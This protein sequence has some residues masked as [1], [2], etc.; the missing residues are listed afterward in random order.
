M[1]ITVDTSGTNIA[2]VQFSVSKEDFDKEYKRGLNQV[3]SQ[4]R[5][6]G[7]RPGKVPMPMIEKH[8]GAEVRDEVKQQFLSRAY[9]KAVEDN[10]LK[11]M[12][13]PRVQ[14]DDAKMEDGG[15]FSMA[16]EIS[17]RPQFPMPD[18][19]GMSIESELEPVLDQNVDEALEEFRRQ[20][21][22]TEATE[23]GIDEKGLVLCNVIFRTGETEAFHRDG[24]RLSPES[25][26]PGVDKE[27]YTAAMIGKKAGETVELDM[28][29]PDTLPDESL[30]GQ[31]GT[32][33]IEITQ[34]FRTVPPT[35]EELCELLQLETTDE[36]RVKVRESLEE[37]AREREN[38]RVETVLLDRLIEAVEIELPEPVLEDQTQNRLAGMAQRMA[39][40]GVPQDEI[41]KERENQKDTARDEAGKGLKALL[42]VEALGE[43]EDLLVNHEDIQAELHQIAMRNRTTAEEVRKY[44]AERNLGQQMAIELLERKV[45]AFLREHAQISEPA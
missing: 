38:N 8:H 37:A 6:K 20:Q 11:P 32:C 26:P 39:Q 43:K 41:E 35:D 9:S 25:A 1:E 40:A 4:A 30:R 44:Y 16:F 21:S 31:P 36:L 42:I 33:V 10:N 34:A 2:K 19:K 45:R 5:M 14:K 18:Y 27:A 17:L 15:G 24:L 28:T 13:H 29:L 7:F 22:R 23:E 3:R 12:A